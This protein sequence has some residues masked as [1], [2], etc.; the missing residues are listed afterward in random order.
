V[1]ELELMAGVPST[2]LSGSAWWQACGVTRAALS[3][4]N[5]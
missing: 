1:S 4:Y 3:V 5:W 2:G